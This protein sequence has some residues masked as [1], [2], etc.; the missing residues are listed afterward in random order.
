MDYHFITKERFEDMVKGGELLEWAE[1]YGNSYGVPRRQVKEALER[2][3]DVLVQ[4]DV[5]GAATIKRAVP[6]ALLI[7]LA[8]PSMEAL[9]ARLR[10]RS[11]ESTI[12]LE[13]RIETAREE[14]EQLPMFDYV[15]VN[16]EVELA[17]GEIEAI[18]TAEKYRVIPRVVEI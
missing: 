2:G 12:D 10:K 13:R 17:A 18:I 6:Q 8:P 7:F 1:V 5:Q 15:V 3:R 4:V 14:M 9:E 11:T 16:D